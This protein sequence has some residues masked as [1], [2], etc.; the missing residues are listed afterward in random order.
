MPSKL[1]AED[2]MQMLKLIPTGVTICDGDLEE[3]FGQYE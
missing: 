1:K 3:I 2:I